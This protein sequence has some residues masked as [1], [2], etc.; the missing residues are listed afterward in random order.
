MEEAPLALR[1]STYEAEVLNALARVL[2]PDLVEHEHRGQVDWPPV[3]ALVRGPSKV[4]AVVI[5]E[6]LSSVAAVNR[7]AGLALHM[8]AGTPLLVVT[9]HARSVWKPT[10]RE[11]RS[12]FGR[13]TI[14]AWGSPQDDKNLASLLREA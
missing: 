8:P 6:N 10:D 4:V 9:S 14:A 3:D 5:E 1:A 12:P 13:L 7:L 2:P 11:F